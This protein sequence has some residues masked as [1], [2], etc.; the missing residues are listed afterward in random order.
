MAIPDVPHCEKPYIAHACPLAQHDSSAQPDHQ[1]S[2]LDNLD[3]ELTLCCHEVSSFPSL[4]VHIHHM[5]RRVV[6]SDVCYGAFHCLLCCDV[7]I[8]GV[9]GK[10]GSFVQHIQVHLGVQYRSILRLPSLRG[11]GG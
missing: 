11:E 7:G 6:R 2:P 9:G 5:V 4:L 8:P 1:L 3:F 10:F